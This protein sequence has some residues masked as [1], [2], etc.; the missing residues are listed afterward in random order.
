MCFLAALSSGLSATTTAGISGKTT[1]CQGV[2]LPLAPSAKVYRPGSR[3][4][5]KGF[6]GGR[7][8]QCSAVACD[9]ATRSFGGDF[10]QPYHVNEVLPYIVVRLST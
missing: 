2:R 6:S 5:F 3:Q 9:D 4:R 7:R 10:T 8:L 1:L